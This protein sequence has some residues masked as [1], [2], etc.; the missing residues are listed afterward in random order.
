[1]TGAG[2]AAGQ[3]GQPGIAATPGTV[4][5]WVF[6]L[7]GDERHHSDYDHAT[8]TDNGASELYYHS[9][10]IALSVSNGDNFVVSFH[11]D[12][13]RHHRPE[14]RERERHDRKAQ[15]CS[16]YNDDEGPCPGREDF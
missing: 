12:A 3:A 5:L 9:R 11:F 7:D 6:Q 4:G 13:N 14:F 10:S 15:N 8:S 2:G 1:Q 16:R